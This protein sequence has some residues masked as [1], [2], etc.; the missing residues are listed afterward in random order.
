M[1]EAVLLWRLFSWKAWRHYPVFFSYFLYLVG[2]QILLQLIIGDRSQSYG[3]WYWVTGLLASGFELIVAWEISRKLL[4]PGSPA[5]RAAGVLLAAILAGL[6][7]FYHFLGVRGI[8]LAVDSQINL[9]FAVAVWL[10]GTLGAA[11]YYD[12][13]QNRNAWGI[14]L[15]TGIYASASVVNLSVYGLNQAAFPVIQHVGPWSFVAVLVIWMWTL[16]SH[17]PASRHP[18]FDRPASSAGGAPFLDDVAAKIR[19]ALGM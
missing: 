6:A 3:L 4:P 8:S 15:G 16:W 13:P 17:T 5:Y 1:L 19:K 12:L 10:F 11:R 18:T 9:S 2:R 7:V 14:A